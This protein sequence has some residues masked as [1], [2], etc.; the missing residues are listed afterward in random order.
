MNQ[1]HSLQAIGAICLQNN[2]AWNGLGT[3][4]RQTKEGVFLYDWLNRMEQITRDAFSR[5]I[6]TMSEQIWLQMLKKDKK[7]NWH[8]D[9]MPL[10]RVWDALV[11]WNAKRI[12][13]L[14]TY[15]PLLLSPSLL[16][17]LSCLLL[18]SI[19][20]SFLSFPP[21]FL[22]SLSLIATLFCYINWGDPNTWMSLSSSTSF[23]L[24]RFFCLWSF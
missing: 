14:C 3:R 9:S 20:L 24:G 12:S 18:S 13:F 22:L 11:W 17:P 5:E 6:F 16:P 7:N 4:F 10:E 1:E 19:S 21:L 8:R 2:D 15:L 23:C